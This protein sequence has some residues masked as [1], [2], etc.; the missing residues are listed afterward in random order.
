VTQ[1]KASGYRGIH[2][3]FEYRSKQSSRNRSSGGDKWNGLHIEIQYRTRVQHAW[4][5]AVEICD[6]FTDNH[7]KFSN[8]PDDYLRYFFLASEILRRVYESE[9]PPVTDLQ[10]KDLLAEFVNLEDQHGL[11]RTLRGIRPSKGDFSLKKHTLLI[12]REEEVETSEDD[13]FSVEVLTFDDFREAVTAYFELE[14]TKN[15]ETDV[16]LV[17]ADDAESVRFGFKNYFSDAREFVELIDAA[18]VAL[19][20]EI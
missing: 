1:P 15:A 2:D 20:K 6:N 7:G 14:R 13:P 17:A 16:V 8:A 4:A 5:T 10:T 18:L 11:L 12:T 9:M 3:V 19:R